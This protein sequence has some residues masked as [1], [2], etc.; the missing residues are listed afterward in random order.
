MAAI[1]NYTIFTNVCFTTAYIQ[2]PTTPVYLLPK[3]FLI[4]YLLALG[5]A[6]AVNVVIFP[7]T[8]RTVFM[9]C[10]PLLWPD[11]EFL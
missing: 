8:S 1:I 2:P 11:I 5:L 3:S 4:D 10:Q 9:V 6:F 7:V